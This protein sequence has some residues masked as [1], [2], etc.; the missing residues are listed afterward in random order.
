MVLATALGW[1][2]VLSELLPFSGLRG[3]A[4]SE[5]ALW[6]LT[7]SLATQPPEEKSMADSHARSFSCC[8]RARAPSCMV[9]GLSDCDRDHLTFPPKLFAENLT[10]S[11]SQHSTV[12]GPGEAKVQT[13]SVRLA[14]EAWEVSGGDPSCSREPLLSSQAWLLLQHPG[15]GCG[16]WGAPYGVRSRHPR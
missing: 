5:S 10:S 15:V 11:A 9:A 14:C 12:P 2:C 6:P 13:F 1:L 7:N 16:Q 3:E 4:R 8:L